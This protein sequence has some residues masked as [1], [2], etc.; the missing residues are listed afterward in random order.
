MNQP[1]QDPVSVIINVFN[2][3]D[4]IER[5]VRDIHA[6]IIA[7]LPGSE[8]IVAEDGSTDGTKEA[9]RRLQ[10]ELGIVHSTSEQRKGYAKAFRDAVALA[11]NPYIFFSDSGGKQ[12]FADFWKLYEYRGQYGIVSGYRSGRTDQLYRRLMT[13]CY[14][15]LLRCYFGVQL[16]DADAGFRI[17]Q[18][19][20]IRKIANE[21]WTNRNLISS[22]LALRAIYSGYVVKEVPVLYRPRAG[23][24]RG[25]P[26][27]KIPKVI[28]AVLRNFS[29]LKKELTS[30]GYR[31]ARPADAG[32]GT[33]GLGPSS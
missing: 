29:R 18:A 11:R 4:T 27:G 30:P 26:L 32:V 9:L 12:D 17:Y 3:A 31:T 28:V 13:W 19:Q 15:F 16:R 5:E 10:A 14:N 2:E 1:E 25:L 8:L 21:P 23:A 33:S 7:R 20:L 22:E 6:E 24:S